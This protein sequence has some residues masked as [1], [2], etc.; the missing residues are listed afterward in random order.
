MI[1]GA[2][3]VV[4][5]DIPDNCVAAGNPARV[6]CSLEAYYEKRKA[7]QYEEAA[8]MVRAYRRSH[9]CEPD[10]HALNEYFW[11]FTRDPKDL[12]P[13]W[14]AQMHLVGNYDPE[15]SEWGNPLEQYSSN[16]R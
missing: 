10:D 9:G 12:C 4:T 15:I 14:D 5:H 7:A 3:S 16:V 11:L 2:G 1:I 13:D 8:Q 6:I